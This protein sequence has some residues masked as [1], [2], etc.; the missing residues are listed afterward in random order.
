M[1]AGTRKIIVLAV[2]LSLFCLMGSVFAQT[3]F[4]GSVSEV[5][6]ERQKTVYT[7]QIISSVPFRRGDV[8]AAVADGRV[9]HYDSSGTLLGTLNT[10]LDGFTTGMATDSAGNLYVTNFSQGVVSILPGLWPR[11]WFNIISI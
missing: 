9:Q 6:K 2:A 11:D 1:D 5:I 4:P 10:G 3:P 8:F 7:R